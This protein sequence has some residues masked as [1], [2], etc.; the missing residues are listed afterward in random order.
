MRG[1]AAVIV[2]IRFESAGCPERGNEG[3]EYIVDVQSERPLVTSFEKQVKRGLIREAPMM[4]LPGLWVDVRL[5]RLD[6]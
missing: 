1:G 4:E 2:L 5:G 3:I 6:W